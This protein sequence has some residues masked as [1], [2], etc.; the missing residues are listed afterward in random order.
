[1]LLCHIERVSVDNAR[2]AKQRVHY[3]HL[4]V[5]CDTKA[6]YIGEVRLGWEFQRER[7]G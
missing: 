5:Q 7:L 1:M 4:G 2:T 6:C 3:E